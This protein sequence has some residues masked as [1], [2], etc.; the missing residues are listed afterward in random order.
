MLDLSA[1]V[2]TRSGIGVSL[3]G[4]YEGSKYLDAK[5]TV[6]LDPFFTVDGRVSWRWRNYTFGV[7]AQNLLDE[8]YA[9]DG[10][11]TGN[12]FVFPGPPRRVLAEFGVA[13]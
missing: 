5:N 4:K 12:L 9:T 7:S 2:S 13:F 3:S 11:T 10:D 8:K 1:D 6:L